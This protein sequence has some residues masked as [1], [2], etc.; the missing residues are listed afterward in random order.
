MTAMRQSTISI[1]NLANRVSELSTQ[2]IKY[3]DESKYAHPDFTSKSP[4]APET[5]AYEGLRNQLTDA[6]LDLVR[7]VSGSKNTFRTLSFWHTDLAAIQVALHR[8]FFECVPD[9]NIGL[10]ASE[11]AKATS[12]DVDRA[13]R[14]LKMLATHRI[15]EEAEG[16]FHHTA[17]S[18]FLKTHVYA[19]M[20]EEQLELFSRASGEMSEWVDAS[21]LEIDAKDSP[22]FRHFGELFYDYHDR[23][24]EKAKRFSD[25]MRSWSTSM[26]A[27]D[28]W[29]RLT[30][31]AVDNSYTVLRDRFEWSNL[32]NTKVVD[33]GGG[34]G[35]VCVDLARVSINA[36]L[37]TTIH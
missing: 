8:K 23:R 17:A 31:L 25:A 16:K 22:F 34:N 26:Y 3:L 35:H 29:Q 2:I 30:P 14:I 36:R 20:A 32:T 21:P 33:I 11:V 27:R 13:N 5:Y 12:I 28:R 6:A 4:D 10:S 7:L 19:A 9:D 37:Q 24:P 18:V 1:A 15:F